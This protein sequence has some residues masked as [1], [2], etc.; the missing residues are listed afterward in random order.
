VGTDTGAIVLSLDGTAGYGTAGAPVIDTADSYTVSAWA[1]LSSIPT[2]YA[3][4]A[5]EAGNEASGFYLEYDPNNKAWCMNFMQTDTASTSG[6]ASIPCA[7]T[8]PAANTWYHLVATY[9]AT[10]QTAQLFVNG[11]PAG[12]ATGIAGWN[13]TGAMLIGAD[14]YNATVGDY[15]PGEISNVQLFNY[16]LSAP[17]I[18]ALYKQI[19]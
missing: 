9:N 6:V 3:T 4:V 19:S 17:Q 1:D 12:I 7:G 14:Q 15:F 5:A 18:A 16:A 2:G 8:T 10:T 13:A 11:A